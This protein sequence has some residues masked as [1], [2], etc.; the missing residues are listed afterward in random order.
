M[1]ALREIAQALST[2]WD[3]DTTL[4]L[5]VRK[6]TEVMQVDSSTIY[7][8]DPDGDTLILRASTGLAKRALGRAS[9]KVGQ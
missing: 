9:L 6:T 5:I 7:L 4:D 8:L 1:S 2:A 3:L